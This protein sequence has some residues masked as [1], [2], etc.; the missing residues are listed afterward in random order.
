M[1]SPIA[2]AGS[3]P[4]CKASIRKGLR[5]LAAGCA[6]LTA[7]CSGPPSAPFVGP[8]PADRTVRV[9]PAVYRSATGPYRTERPVEPRPWDEQNERVAPAPKP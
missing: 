1:F 4:S 9:P 8:D 5:A 2:P 3:S 6:L 7:A